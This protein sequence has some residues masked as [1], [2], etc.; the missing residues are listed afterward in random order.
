MA[1]LG[2]LAVT[3]TWVLLNLSNEVGPEIEMPNLNQYTKIDIAPEQ[4]KVSTEN[5]DI[6]NG[7]KLVDSNLGTWWH[8]KVPKPYT[9]EEWVIIDFGKSTR[10]DLIRVWPRISFRNQFWDNGNAEL[11]GSHDGKWWQFIMKLEVNKQE[12]I[13]YD[14]SSV[15]FSLKGDE[16]N[17]RYYKIL[18]RDRSFSSMA[19][20]AM[21]TKEEP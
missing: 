12:L 3:S 1:I 7:A 15:T 4:I 14:R 13:K 8:T 11:H 20:L 17:F 9:R 16:A 21:Y 10:V 2:I 19:E 6:E 18:I 5:S